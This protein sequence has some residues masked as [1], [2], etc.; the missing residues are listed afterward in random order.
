M[1]KWACFLFVLITLS[2]CGVQSRIVDDI[3]LATV[4][5]YDYVSND[6]V[7]SIIS[8]PTYNPDKSITNK[9]YSDVAPL[10]RE[11]KSKMDAKSS[12]EILAGKLAVAV[13]NEDLA[14]HGLFKY[15]DY[16][17]RDPDIGTRVS[18]VIAKNKVEDII[19]PTN[20]YDEQ[21]AGIYLDNLLEQNEQNSIL[22]RTNLHTFYYQYYAKGMDPYLPLMV[23]EGN[24]VSFDG[25]ALFKS[26]KYVGSIPFDRMFAFN[27]LVEKFNHGVIPIH[28][29]VESTVIENIKGS[30]RISVHYKNGIP[31]ATIHLK[32]S[33]IIREYKG[34]EI[35][36]GKLVNL[37]NDFKTE[38]EKETQSL[39]RQLQKLNVDPIGLGDKARSQNRGF[40]LNK[41]HEDYPTMTINVVV[42]TKL[43]EFGIER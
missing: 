17:V 12:R 20:D 42:T 11:D 18:I 29:G 5:G 6:Q 36:S 32:V 24:Q 35:T 21:D 40:N 43:S 1:K 25:I 8:T 41:W 15:V 2:G 31:K 22:P 23:K 7:K 39:T 37:N 19:N 10:V 27:L 9:F 4:V 34:K 28:K 38:L 13:F 30:R 33:G 26:D 16:L 3:S 14:K